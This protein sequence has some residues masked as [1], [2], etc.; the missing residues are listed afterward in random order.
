MKRCCVIVVTLLIFSGCSKKLTKNAAEDI[1]LKEYSNFN[2]TAKI[3]ETVEKKDGFYIKWENKGNLHD[4][5]AKVDKT[6][7][8]EIITEEIS[9]ELK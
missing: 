7:K 9:S 1:I 2:G 6:G 3:I 5:Y 8:I 4:G